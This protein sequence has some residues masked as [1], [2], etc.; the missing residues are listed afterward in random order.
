MSDTA[1]CRAPTTRTDMYV[2]ISDW[3]MHVTN[4]H[5]PATLCYQSP[6]GVDVGL[7]ATY[8]CNEPIFGRYVSIQRLQLRW[9]SVTEVEVF[10]N[11]YLL[12]YVCILPGCRLG[13]CLLCISRLVCL[14]SYISRT[15]RDQCDSVPPYMR[16]QVYLGCLE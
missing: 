6:P 12:D 16:I 1:C 14:L 13:K 2:Y 9:W 3:N 5:F 10:V 15:S 8:V 4:V 7:N 11:R